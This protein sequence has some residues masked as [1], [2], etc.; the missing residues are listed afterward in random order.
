MKTLALPFYLTLILQSG[1]IDFDSL[2]DSACQL[3]FGVTRLDVVKYINSAHADG[4]V[5]VDKEGRYLIAA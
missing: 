3:G 5:V 4:R 2:V 1:P